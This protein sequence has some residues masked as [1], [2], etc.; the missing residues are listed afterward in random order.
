MIVLDTHAWIWWINESDKLSDK[1]KIAIQQ[2][3]SVGVSAIS[4]WEVAMLVSKERIGF[5]VDVQE[6]IEIALKRPKVKLL[7]I[8]PEIAVRSTRLADNFHGDPSDRL[9]V[10]TSLVHKSHLVSKD[11]KITDSRLV[12]VVW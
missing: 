4:C 2:S 11:R 1:A 10:A 7:P 6:W 9:I 3:D 8:T 5:S 12:T